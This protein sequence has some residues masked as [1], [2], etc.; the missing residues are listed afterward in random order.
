MKTNTRKT[1]TRDPLEDS[2]LDGVTLALRLPCKI[3]L[4]V[5]AV[6]VLS[7]TFLGFF[8]IPDVLDMIWGDGK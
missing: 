4:T 7:F 2:F 5:L 3:M 8:M 6:T 1:E